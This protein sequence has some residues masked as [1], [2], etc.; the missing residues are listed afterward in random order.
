M[1][2][3]WTNE[4]IDKKPGWEQAHPGRL[5]WEMAELRAFGRVI[6]VS[7]EEWCLGKLHLLYDWQRGDNIYPIEIRYPPTFPRVRPSLYLMVPKEQRPA[8]HCDPTNGRLCYLGHAPHEWKPGNSIARLI[9][10]QLPLILDG[11]FDGIE[12]EIGEPA[13]TWFNVYAPENSCAL[14]ETRWS[15]EGAATGSVRARHNFSDRSSESIRMV[16]QEVLND[17]GTA[18][19]K[20]RGPIPVE[21]ADKPII[22]F[23]WIGSDV[24][25]PPGSALEVHDEYRAKLGARVRPRKLSQ[26]VYGY[27]FAIIHPTEIQFR[28]IGES[29][30]I[31]IVT[32]PERAFKGVPGL[33][34]KIATVRIFRGGA[35][36]LVSRAPQAVA[37][38]DKH[39]VVAGLGAIGAPIALE[40]ARNGTLRLGMID[41]DYV[42]PGNSVRWPFGQP[43]WGIGKTSALESFIKAN[44]PACNTQTLPIDIAEVLGARTKLSRDL[45]AL[46]SSADIVVEATAEHGV[47]AALHDF[48]AP[49]GV[50]IISVNATPSVAGGAVVLYRPGRGCPT[51]LIHHQNDPKSTI[52]IPPGEADRGSLVHIPGCA[53]VTFTG[54]S[55]DLAELSNQA[56]RFVI[57]GLMQ[58]ATGGSL[59]ATFGFSEAN[60][61]RFPTWQIQKMD[62]H[63]ACNCT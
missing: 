49:R 24:E 36:D 42:S 58:D 53:A 16:V 61:I 9:N 54:T 59:V 1:V 17:R 6:D 31:F 2:D 41:Y 4:P 3:W 29:W 47:L 15:T 35:E 52:A 5:A 37:L 56:I 39:V 27:L 32:G 63:E 34:P 7:K 46:L 60:E 10:E 20:W 21:F 18:L 13:E 57:A 38:R 23:P 28:E 30:I 19:A 40:L 14:V 8:R 50:T 25:L 62:R 48:C 44:Y 33:R 12:E 51:C 45:A 22:E 26:G 43:Y 11:K 55:F